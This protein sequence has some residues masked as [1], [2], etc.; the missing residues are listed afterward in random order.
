MKADRICSTYMHAEKT[1]KIHHV[2]SHIVIISIMYSR[3]VYKGRV[4]F[5]P[6]IKVPVDFTDI[7]SAV[8]AA[9]P[10]D[11]ILVENGVYNE[12]VIIRHK[13]NLLIKAGGD[14]VIIDGRGLT[15][16]TIGFYV[17]NSA[18]IEI[19]GFKIKEFDKGII[20][21]GLSHNI[22]IM[23][24]TIK[25]IRDDGVKIKGNNCCFTNN[26]I[27]KCK[28]DAVK[29]TA[30]NCIVMNNN[31]ENN[32]EEGIEIN[33]DFNTVSKNISRDNSGIGLEVT[34]TGN[35]AADNKL[36]NNKTD[37]AD[38]GTHNSIENKNEQSTADK[39]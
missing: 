38:T 15:P 23:E 22:T 24:N 30:S 16:P 9:V 34:G 8:N 12:Q 18:K 4:N 7:Q 3:E 35:T 27:R 20:I 5:M 29:V 1:A 31:I 14:G 17:V 13:K 33:G 2:L 19:L 26:N 28:D 10:G 11:E 21:D 36:I 32:G 37:I 6:A 25:D 39:K